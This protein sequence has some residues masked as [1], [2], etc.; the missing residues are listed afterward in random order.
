MF[1]Y[2]SSLIACMHS[3]SKPSATNSHFVA[4]AA[5]KSV[6]HRGLF[7]GYIPFFQFVLNKQP[8][9]SR[10]NAPL[11]IEPNCSLNCEA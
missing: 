3:T 11:P 6:R 5:R 4:E 7:Q 1:L 2:L 9:Q 10:L 8:H